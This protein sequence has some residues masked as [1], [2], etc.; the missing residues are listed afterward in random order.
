MVLDPLEL[1]LEMVVH[2]HVGAGNKPSPL[3]EQTVLLTSGP[4]LQY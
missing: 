3:Q 1:D 2:C 4:T